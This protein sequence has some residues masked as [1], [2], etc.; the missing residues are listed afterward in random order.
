MEENSKN[1]NFIK[2]FDEHGIL[3][4]FSSARTP[5]QN[6]VVQRKNRTL[7]NISSIVLAENNLSKYFW[8]EAIN[9]A[10]YIMNKIMI[11]PIIKKTSYGLLK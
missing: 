7:L 5:Q 2:F 11:R 6:D 10:Y 4:K 1:L 8:A 3:H 9:V